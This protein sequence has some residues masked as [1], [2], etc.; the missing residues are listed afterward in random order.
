AMCSPAHSSAES[1]G[2]AA[3]ATERRGF[4][5]D[6][7]FVGSLPA[8]GPSGRTIRGRIFHLLAA[9]V[10]REIELPSELGGG[11]TE[12][13]SLHFAGWHAFR[14]SSMEPRTPPLL[15]N[16]VSFTPRAAAV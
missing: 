13:G 2:A 11:I 16:N 4:S 12:G 15:F 14:S 6:G 1:T 10:P 5:G 7:G 3:T 8:P 9:G